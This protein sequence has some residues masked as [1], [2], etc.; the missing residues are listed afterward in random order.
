MSHTVKQS[1][2]IP[3]HGESISI[4]EGRLVVPS[5]PIIPFIRGDGIS[6]DITPV[7]QQV[8]DAAVSKA[9]GGK[10]SIKWMRIL[11]GDDALEAHG[12]K[13]EEIAKHPVSE[14]Q[15][16]CLPKETIELIRKHLIAIK[17]PLTT[18]IGGGIRSPNVTLRQILDLYACVRPV[19]WFRGVPAPLKK[20]ENLDV[21]IFRENTEDVYAGIEWAAGTDEATRIRGFLVKEMG[22]SI[23]EDSAIG[24]KP[25]SAIASKRLVRA[26]INYALKNKRRS[27]T[28]VHKGNIMKYTEGAFS[29]WGY[30]VATEEFREA[31]VTEREYGPLH[32]RNEYP[33]ITY[34]EMVD[35][36]TERGWPGFNV[37]EAKQ[38]VSSLYKTHGKDKLSQKLLIKDRIADQMFQQLL[39]RPDEYDVIATLNLNGDYLSDACSAEVG[40]LGIAPGANIN[41]E[42]G[43]A[44]FEAIHGTAPKYAGLDKANPS[45]LILSAVLML[46]YMGWNEAAKLTEQALENTILQKTV[47]YDLARQMEDATELGTSQ[48]GEAMMKNIR[49]SA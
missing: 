6:I 4:S 13:A 30:E 26:S 38:I 35:R 23:R 11:A 3:K 34:E 48:F 14:Q 10:R 31:V 46:N 45:S 5:N 43:V 36:L 28:L 19:R 9:Y 49:A 44:V 39:L 17:G 24:I 40:G 37:S 18:P 22:A 21:V 8:V 12:I 41:Y 15:E 2:T 25:V 29:N 47:T 27:V 32:I 16:L 7:M 42:T 33:E 20:P 1:S